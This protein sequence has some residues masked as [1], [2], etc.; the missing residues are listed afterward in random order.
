[1]KANK[2]RSLLKF[3]LVFVLFV[4][5]V[6]CR[7]QDLISE[8]QS[9]HPPIDQVKTG[10]EV[11]FHVDVKNPDGKSL[12]FVWSADRGTVNPSQKKPR[13]MTYH[14][15][16]EE[17]QDTVSLEVY[18]E[19]KGTI[20]ATKTLT[21]T[22][23][24]LFELLEGFDKEK[25]KIFRPGTRINYPDKHRGISVPKPVEPELKSDPSKKSKKFPTEGKK[26]GLFKFGPANGDNQEAAFD[27]RTSRDLTPYVGFRFDCYNPTDWS[28]SF[29]FGI[30][31]KKGKTFPWTE[32]EG[33]ICPQGEVATIE[34][35][36]KDPIF[37]SRVYT[38][39]QRIVIIIV[40]S[41]ADQGE[42]Y[43]DNI[44]FI[45]K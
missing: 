29:R 45:L 31:S 8:I 24:S 22:I 5:A 3:V 15:P 7:A 11:T 10:E 32:Y 1:M 6:L 44:G 19:K 35:D 30:S 18:D 36:L 2:P 12:K 42:V 20:I 43:I 27:H 4:P 13:F 39:I 37:G 28:I 33:D 14:A 26:A 16:K 34:F 9:D 17:G 23:Y 41:N 21:L 40:P 25:I 38:G